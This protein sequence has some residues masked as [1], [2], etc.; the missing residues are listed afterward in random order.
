M[1]FSK[2]LDITKRHFDIILVDNPPLLEVPDAAPLSSLA[3]GVVFVIR[4]GCL[5]F[6]AISEALLPLKE[7]GANILGTVINQAKISKNYY[8]Y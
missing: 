8:K 3:D 1:L 2:F 7:T 6:K 4:A 5:S